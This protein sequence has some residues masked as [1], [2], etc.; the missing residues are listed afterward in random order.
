MLLAWGDVAQTRPSSQGRPL[1]LRPLDIG[2]SPGS[3]CAG[4]WKEVVNSPSDT[5]APLA[6][7][8]ENSHG[9]T[10]TT[11]LSTHFLPSCRKARTPLFITTEK[12]DFKWSECHHCGMVANGNLFPTGRS[13]PG[14]ELTSVLCVPG[15]IAFPTICPS[16]TVVIEWY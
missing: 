4:L 6:L 7:E 10:P 9:A 2:G 8:V 16:G 1:A 12:G 3:C 11:V 15:T 5:L 14:V 13:L